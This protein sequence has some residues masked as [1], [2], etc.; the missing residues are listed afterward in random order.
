MFDCVESKSIIFYMKQSDC[1]WM[2]SSI[3]RSTTQRLT[4]GRPGK[5]KKIC[6]YCV[7]FDHAYW[8]VTFLL[9]SSMYFDKRKANKLP[10]CFCRFSESVRK[11]NIYK[12]VLFLFVHN[13]FSV[14][15]LSHTYIC[16]CFFFFT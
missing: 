7:N 4:D 14:S 8:T 5:V 11:V 3:N 9:I 10:V 1:I 12:I 2:A 13:S 6:C 16:E 15:V